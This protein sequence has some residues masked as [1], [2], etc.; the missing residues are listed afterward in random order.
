MAILKIKG[1]DTGI[2]KS[3]MISILA[4]ALEFSK[5][6]SDELIKAVSAGRVIT[7][8]IAE[9]AEAEAMYN[10]LREVGAIVT[11]TAE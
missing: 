7:L 10:K 4:E 9:D 11:T 6:E 5:E 2:N 3:K 8:E 1:W